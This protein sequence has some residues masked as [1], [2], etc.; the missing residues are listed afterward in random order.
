MSKVVEMAFPSEAPK[1][2]IEDIMDNPEKLTTLQRI[3]GGGPN[4]SLEVLKLQREMSN[5]GKKWDLAMKQLDRNWEAEKA[6]LYAEDR[7]G[8]RLEG[9]VTKIL[10]TATEALGE[11][12]DG[13]QSAQQNAKTTGSDII[14]QQ[15]PVCVENKRSAS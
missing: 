9:M 11:G 1:S 6:K 10:N 13:G 15:C 3:T 8:K 12:D 5:D 2:W 14:S 7:R 4:G